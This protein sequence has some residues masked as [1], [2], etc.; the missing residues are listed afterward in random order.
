MTLPEYYSKFGI[1][2]DPYQMEI[3]DF[4]TI[5]T[6][7]TNGRVRQRDG[8]IF[9]YRNGIL[10]NKEKPVINVNVEPVVSYNPSLLRQPDGRITMPDGSVRTYK[11]GKVTS[12]MYSGL[13]PPEQRLSPDQI[14]AQEGIPPYEQLKTMYPQAYQALLKKYAGDPDADAKIE[15]TL[16]RGHKTGYQPQTPNINPDGTIDPETSDPTPVTPPQPVPLVLFTG[17]REMPDGS[18]RIYKNGK[19][20]G[21]IYPAGFSRENMLDAKGIKALNRNEGDYYDPNPTTPV[22][23]V[24][25]TE[26]TQSLKQ[27]DV[28]MPDGSIRTYEN[29][30]VVYVKYPGAIKSKTPAEINKEEGIRDASY[31]APVAPVTP[32]APVVPLQQGVV[33]MPDGSKRM[34]IDGKVVSVVYP[35]GVTGPTI[36]Q[37]NAAEGTKTAEPDSNNPV[38]PVAPVDPGGLPTQ[39]PTPTQPDREPTYEELQVMYGG[40]Y[41]QYLRSYANEARYTDTPTSPER[42]AEMMEAL[43]RAEHTNRTQAGTAP[44]LPP[45]TT[46]PTPTT[47]QPLPFVPGA[48]SYEYTDSGTQAPTTTTTPTTPSGGGPSDYRPR[49]QEPMPTTTTTTPSGG[50]PSDYRPRQAEPISLARQAPAQ[51]ISPAAIPP[52]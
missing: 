6:T 17:D 29:G 48:K 21:I 40:S 12:V 11:D 28:K 24:T 8:T 19:V 1:P 49:G 9:T 38:N 10:V 27:G 32:V 47:N 51:T 52:S 41:R 4:H 15:E 44:P 34:Y 36:N 30:L 22:T 45:T 42:Q 35:E 26:P 46:T 43:L 37:I 13:T 20:T 25:P 50:G 3:V 7:P 16:A 18:T 23:P 33:K 31:T 14:N 5:T 2:V 39:I